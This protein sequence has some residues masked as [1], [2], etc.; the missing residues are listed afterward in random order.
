MINDK[1]LIGYFEVCMWISVVLAGMVGLVIF[2]VLLIPLIAVVL[3]W[4]SLVWIYDWIS[5]HCGRMVY[6]V[7]FRKKQ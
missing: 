3:T 1:I 5:M 2:A 7:R 6:S 4:E